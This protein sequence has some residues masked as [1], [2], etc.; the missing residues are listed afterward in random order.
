VQLLAWIG[1]RRQVEVAL[2]AGRR[3]LERLPYPDNLDNHFVVGPAKF[4]FYAMDCYAL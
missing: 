2:D 4:D 1:D 3:V